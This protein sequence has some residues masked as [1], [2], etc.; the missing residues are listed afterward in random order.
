VS[1]EAARASRF[2]AL[3]EAL[4]GDRTSFW[5]YL[6][7][8]IVPALASIYT[9]RVLVALMTREEY[10]EWGYLGTVARMLVP[11]A[12]L[13][14]PAAMMRTYF[15]HARDDDDAHATL[16]ST[17]LRLVAGGA[18]LVTLG[19]I[20][21]WLV[22]FSTPAAALYLATM[23]PG[24]VFASYFDYLA[25]ARNDYAIYLLGRLANSLGFLV[26]AAVFERTLAPVPAESRRALFH[27][28]VAAACCA[29][30]AILVSV[31]FYA[32]RRVLSAA[33]KRLDRDAVR[34]LV[35]FSAPISGTFFL[36]WLLSSFPVWALRN[37]STPAEVADF[38]FA[39]GI[40][41]V[42]SLVT[43]SALT[44]WPRFYYAEMRDARPDRDARIARK[45]RGFLWMH[46]AALVVLRLVA[47]FGYT[48]LG[49]EAYEGGLAYV[50]WL[51]LGNFFFLAG[52]MLAAGLGQA[53]RTDLAAL[54]FAL[55]AGLTVA[56]QLALVP[57][58]GARAAALVNLGGFALFALASH[59]LGRRF[60][61]FAEPA[62]TLGPV[63]AACAVA[64]APL[65]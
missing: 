1:T 10:G 51:A 58:F 2:R 16:A 36:G 23:A 12:S 5:V 44:D 54:T 59:L 20:T 9:I 55:P 37:R 64:L 8:Q 46:V 28:T 17:V 34:A 25:R 45:L 14:L 21:S 61:A 47:R 57:H 32:R 3:L 43:Q 35:R 42:V 33:A 7:A 60:Y 4:R 19:T 41:G 40:V 63:A 56:L 48:L 24:L 27:A 49:A 15:D 26:V 11:I 31:G 30:G 22:G 38:V 6:F 53:K 65:G 50:P 29:W 39:L 52:N 62:R 13:S 18:A